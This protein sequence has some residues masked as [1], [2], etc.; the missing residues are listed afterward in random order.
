[1]NT[2]S[3]NKIPNSYNY[4]GPNHTRPPPP[5]FLWVFN[6]KT[7]PCSSPAH[8]VAASQ[9]LAHVVC[10]DDDI[11]VVNFS[12]HLFAF[13]GQETDGIKGHFKLWACSNET[14]AHGFYIAFPAKLNCNEL[15][16]L[17]VLLL[18]QTIQK[19]YVAC[20]HRTSFVLLRNG[21]ADP[22]P[23]SLTTNKQNKIKE[24]NVRQVCHISANAN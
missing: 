15:A 9:E 12:M 11:I 22:M 18:Q 13:T 6:F 1:M 4:T 2:S 19:K 5:V 24:R 21:K 17:Q 20:C 8:R 16:L 23:L 14:A 3:D 10:L 7:A